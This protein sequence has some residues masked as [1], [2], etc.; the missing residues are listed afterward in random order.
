MNRCVEPELLDSLPPDAPE[1]MASRRDLTL[2]NRIMGHHRIMAGMLLTAWPQLA[3]ARLIELGAGDGAFILQLARLLSPHWSSMTAVLVDRS[4]AVTTATR[5]GLRRLG[6]SVEVVTADV[7]DWLRTPG[8]RYTDVVVA[9]LFLHHFTEELL[10]NLLGQVAATTNL[11]AACEPWRSPV[12]LN[13]SRLV[14]V[15]GCNHVTRNDA[16][17]SVRAGFA[18]QELSQLWPHQPHWQL[19]EGSRRLFTHAFLAHRR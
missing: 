6:W 15:I 12:A 8:R 10:R 17:V 16:V 18:G 3:D 14:G 13:F 4:E 1:A 19:N 11:F 2:L 9:N 5:D 7:F